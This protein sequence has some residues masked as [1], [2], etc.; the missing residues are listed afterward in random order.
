MRGLL[1]SPP[2]TCDYVRCA[3]YILCVLLVACSLFYVLCA[4][5]ALCSVWSV[6]FARPVLYVVGTLIMWWS[7]VNAPHR[8]EPHRTPPHSTAPHRVSYC[9]RRRWRQHLFFSQELYSEAGGTTV[10]VD[11]FTAHVVVLFQTC[12]SLRLF[13][14]CVDLLTAHLGIASY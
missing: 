1:T 9:H 10:V 12:C 11:V 13:V 2:A 3:L 5:R 7:R 4:L 14:H 6:C 8:N